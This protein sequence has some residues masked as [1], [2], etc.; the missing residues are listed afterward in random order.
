[1]TEL[2][3]LY[4][5]GDAYL[6]CALKRPFEAHYRF[7]AKVVVKSA[8]AFLPRWF[9]IDHEINDGIVAEAEHNTRLHETYPN[10]LTGRFYVHP[11][12]VRTPTRLDQLTVKP[13]VSQADMYRALLQLP[14]WTP[15]DR[16]R[17]G[18]SGNTRDVLLLTES[19][20]WPNLPGAF[21]KK[22]LAALHAAGRKVVVNDPVW[23]LHDLLGRCAESRY[24][25]GPQC[26]VVSIACDAGLAGHVTVVLKELSAESPYIFGLS[27]TMP[28][29]HASTFAG[30]PHPEVGHVVV[31][32]DWDSA[33]EAVLD[34][35]TTPF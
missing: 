26:G 34:D 11:H 1:M 4:G 9:D 14:P 10:P 24:V 12:F 33:I 22:L 18:A 15:L 35:C 3:A 5:T 2:V 8:H 28:Y 20:S 17:W 16:P 29:G 27:E 25:V 21:W 30:N 13:R 19:R 6:V 32:D 23:S 31:G 7:K